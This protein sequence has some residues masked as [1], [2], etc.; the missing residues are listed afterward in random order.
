ML[1]RVSC[2]PIPSRGKNRELVDLDVCS[3]EHQTAGGR[4]QGRCAEPPPSGRMPRGEEDGFQRND[5]RPRADKGLCFDLR[6]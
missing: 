3:K 4:V 6:A 2:A 1:S 5:A